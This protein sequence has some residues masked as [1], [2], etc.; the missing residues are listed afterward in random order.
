HYFISG[1]YVEVDHNRV[2]VLA[3]TVEAAK[4]INVAKAEEALKAAQAVLSNL[5]PETDVE[6]AN[7]EL[8]A[9]QA[10]V[11]IARGG[12]IAGAKH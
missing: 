8:K 6:A 12:S 7:R 11:Q 1:G 3:D 2:S 10:R 4:D 5:T 9:A